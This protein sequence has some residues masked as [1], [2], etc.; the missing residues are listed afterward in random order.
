[1]GTRLIG[2]R[3]RCA[4]VLLHEII[5]NQKSFHFLAADVGQHFAI[6]LDAWAKHLPALFNHLLTL[7]GII[8]DVP[9]FVR[10]VV[11]THDRAHALAPAT[12]RFQVSDNFRFIHKSELTLFCHRN[13]KHQSPK[14]QA[15]LGPLRHGT[16]TSLNVLIAPDKFKG[17]LTASAAAQ[18]IARGWARTRPDDSLDLLP[19]TDGGDGFG[20]TMGTLLQAQRISTRTVDAAHRPCLTK[21]WWEP[22]TKTAIIESAAAI[23]LAMLP[24]KR[25][26]PFELDTF[27]L[28]KVMMGAARKGAAR[29]LIGIGGS[30]TNDA[31]FG[32]ARALGW[33]FLD[34]GGRK[35]EKWTELTILRHIQAPRKRHWFNE[36][37]VAVD[38][39]NPLLGKRGA[40]RVYGPQ[41]GI[42]T[43]E[44][45]KAECC[46]RRLAFIYEKDFGKNFAKMAGTGAAGGLGF[47]LATFAGGSLE[48][49]FDLFARQAG[50]SQRLRR[51][52][53]VITGEGCIDHSTLMGKGVGQ[54][55]QQCNKLKIPCIALAG[56]TPSGTRFRRSFDQV[57]ALLDT[58]SKR[59]AMTRTAYWLERLAQ[60]IALSTPFNSH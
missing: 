12:G 50:L 6:D 40:T 10:Q 59:E 47:G 27:G 15:R 60:N 8:D 56:I 54:I 43:N 31:G 51:V 36:L 37:L 44:F 46:L 17:T 18:A 24:P 38:V 9:V 32:L 35:I 23:G 22:K 25:F 3:I 34:S 48:P 13:G 58:T 16:W 1:M 29:C 45:A 26:H 21:W 57:H 53:L 4:L 5:G 55:A 52:D 49:G 19:I 33:Q 7:D 20:E 41:K 14:L 30:A 2:R 28:G 39:Q 42:R 11:F